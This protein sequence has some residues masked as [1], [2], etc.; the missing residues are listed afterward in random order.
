MNKIKYLCFTTLY[1]HILEL[2]AVKRIYLNQ[3]DGSL[4]CDAMES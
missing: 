4:S 2:R 3:I 1:S